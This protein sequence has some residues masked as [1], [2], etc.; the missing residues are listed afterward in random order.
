M[1]ETGDIYAAERDG[2]IVDLSPRM[3]TD[4]A[5]Q[6]WFRELG[7]DAQGCTLVVLD[8][9]DGESPAVGDA[10]DVDPDGVATLARSTGD[11]RC[12]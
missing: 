3:G 10:I 2:V 9:S 4:H 5:A 7:S 1:T 8:L 6:E 12:P 11:A